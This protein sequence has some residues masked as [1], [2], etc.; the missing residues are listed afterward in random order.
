[1]TLETKKERACEATDVWETMLTRRLTDELDAF[2]GETDAEI[3]LFGDETTAPRRIEQNDKRP[4][5]KA[6]AAVAASLAFLVVLAATARVYLAR[7]TSESGAEFRQVDAE[8]SLL[9]WSVE[10]WNETPWARSVE[11]KLA[12]VDVFGAGS[13]SAPEDAATQETTRSGAGGE[14]NAIAEESSKS[15]LESSEW[16]GVEEIADVA[17]VELLKY[18]PFVQAVVASLL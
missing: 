2:L 12:F 11:E 17:Q 13:S 18:E 14:E 5:Y 16:F 7:P 3:F 4:R 1:M 8:P 9:A 15:A 6:L 10:S